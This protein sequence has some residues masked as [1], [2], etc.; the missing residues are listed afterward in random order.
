MKEFGEF[1]EKTL[2]VLIA[3]SKVSHTFDI[4]SYDSILHYFKK[5]WNNIEKKYLKRK[6]DKS[7]KKLEEDGYIRILRQKNNK[8]QIYFTPKGLNAVRMKK[9]KENIKNYPEIKKGERILIFDIPEK[10]RKLRNKFRDFLRIMGYREIQQSVFVSKRENMK[11]L[12]ILI[13]A[14]N[15]NGMVKSGIWIEDDLSEL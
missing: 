12:K 15:M 7:V 14:L 1:L 6:L 2:L 5:D 3:Y 10:E 8:A 13:N 11:D 4:N 9:V